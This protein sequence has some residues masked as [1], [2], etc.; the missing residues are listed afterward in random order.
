ME[1]ITCPNCLSQIT[2][3]ERRYCKPCKVRKCTKCCCDCE[4]KKEAKENG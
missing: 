2:L 1:K 4:I 3:D